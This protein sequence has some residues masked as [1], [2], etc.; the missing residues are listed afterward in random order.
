MTH[1]EAL[2][3]KNKVA[4]MDREIL[5]LLNRRAKTAILLGRRSSLPLPEAFGAASRKD[6]LMA[7]KQ[8]NTGPL[9]DALLERVFVEVVSACRN[10]EP[11]GKIACTGP[12]TSFTFQAAQSHFGKGAEYS[13]QSS[14]CE[15]FR[16]VE[17]DQAIFG[18]VPVDNSLTGPRHATLDRLIDSDLKIIGEILTP[19]TYSL[20]GQNRD[21]SR[22]NKVAGKPNQLELCRNFLNTNLSQAAWIELKDEAQGV[23]MVLQDPKTALLA[24]PQAA[25]VHNLSIIAGD[26]QDSVFNQTRF[27]ILSKAQ[28]PES[29]QDKTSI[30]F[31]APHQPG[32]LLNALAALAEQG[33]NLTRIES[34]PIR[35]KPW[36]YYFFADLEGHVEQP[37]V[38]QALASLEKC[39]SLIKV[40]GSYAKAA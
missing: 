30:L 24:P 14:I 12:E 31:V 18:V 25:Q 34:R 10:N 21:L 38:Q 20:L 4:Q 40:F 11:Q 32:A 16:M 33:I 27:L 39:V 15:V 29:G 19:I 6:A 22:I 5:E 17:R 23:E 9:R 36:D 7:I 26:I 1:D 13:L 3:L 35:D 2:E 28:L 37:E 8:H